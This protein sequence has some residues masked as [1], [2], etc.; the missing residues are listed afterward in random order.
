[1]SMLKHTANSTIWFPKA[2]V[3][4]W[5]STE[6]SKAEEQNGNKK[7]WRCQHVSGSKC[8]CTLEVCAVVRAMLQRVLHVQVEARLGLINF[9]V[10]QK[11]TTRKRSNHASLRNYKVYKLCANSSH[12][13]A[14]RCF[15]SGYESSGLARLPRETPTIHPSQT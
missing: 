9:N 14:T 10:T 6:R 11:P 5:K 15:P 12:V 8:C 3:A 13:A 7:A 2:C 4:V 1:M